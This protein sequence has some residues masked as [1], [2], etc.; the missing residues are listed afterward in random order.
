MN[1]MI[2]IIRIF[3]AVAALLLAIVLII[4]TRIKTQPDQGL[5]PEEGQAC[6]RCKQAR[7]G[8]QGQFHYTE[9]VGNA[10]ERAAKQQLRM[11][12][13]PILGSETH[14]ICDQC[15]RRYIRNEFLQILLMTL[16][17]PLY[18]FVIIPLFLQ[19]RIFAG[20]LIETLLVVLALAGATSAF[21]L[22]RAV[23]LGSRPLTEARDRV[24]VIERKKALGNKFSYYTRMGT[25][26]LHK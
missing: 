16:P 17:Y 24:A 25:A 6:L 22:Y 3:T 2:T 1:V 5:N 18:L 9:S 26:Q 7:K 12:D 23:R 19:E 4:L 15:A 13:T 20:F 11:K 8:A 21:D 10:R 14:F